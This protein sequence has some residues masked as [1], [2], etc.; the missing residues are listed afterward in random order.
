MSNQDTPMELP[1]YIPTLEKVNVEPPEPVD[2]PP[3]PQKPLDEENKKS[4]TID[5]KYTLGNYKKLAKAAKFRIEGVDRPLYGSAQ[6]SYNPYKSRVV[7]DTSRIPLAVPSISMAGLASSVGAIESLNFENDPSARAWAEAMD[8]AYAHNT[9]QDAFITAMNREGSDWKQIPKNGEQ[10]LVGALARRPSTQNSELKDSEA[11]MYALSALKLGAPFQAPMWHSGFWVSFRPASEEAW[12]N[13]NE[14]LTSDKIR[15]GRSASGLAFSNVNAI[16]IKRSLEFAL[17]HVIDH[18]IRTDANFKRRDILK[19]LL[20]PDISIF[21]WGFL[22]ANNPSGYP[23]TRGC[24]ATIGNCTKFIQETINLRILQVTDDSCFEQ[25]H[26]IHM[27][28]NYPGGVT[29]KEVDEYQNTVNLLQEKEVIL[30]KEED[31]EI[32]VV[33]K[34]P[35][36]ESYILSGT[37]WFDG[38]VEMVNSIL[39]KDTTDN[40]REKIYQQYAKSSI[41]REYSHWIKEIRMNTN[42]MIETSTIENILKETTPH[43]VLRETLY[44]KISDYIEATTLSVIAIPNYACPSCGK[45][46]KEELEKDR[47]TD[48]IPLD[49][50]QAFFNLA[51]LRVVEIIRR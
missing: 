23:I 20:T 9:V 51:Q 34:I 19:K 21:L 45:A 8:E 46:Q 4:E 32:R 43:E 6:F 29:E 44:S 25:R 31:N 3:I 37:R 5:V 14:L 47:F 49:L 1:D 12:V 26:R 48:C 10:L 41:M 15:I 22:V 28:K 39:S 17:E 13:F 16:F 18:N 50:A 42:S 38:I 35:N 36:A 11:L 40:Q 24:S 27:S 33:L 7:G 2:T 30:L